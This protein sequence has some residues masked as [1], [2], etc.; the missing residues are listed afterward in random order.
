MDPRLGGWEDV[1]RLSD[2]HVVMSDVIVNHVSRH[3][4]QFQDFDRQGA[5]SPYA[6]LFLTYARVFPH[7]ASQAELLALHTPRPSLPFTTHRTAHGAPVLLWTTFTSDQIDI[8]VPLPV[9]RSTWP[10][11]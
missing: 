2:T 1:Q 10:R 11:P 3:S 6:G 4:P 8:D 7:G 9:P 5:E